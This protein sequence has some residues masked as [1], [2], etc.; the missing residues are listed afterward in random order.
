MD[1]I[2]GGN[3]FTIRILA[4]HQADDAMS[5]TMKQFGDEPATNEEAIQSAKDQVAAFHQPR[6]LEQTWNHVAGDLSGRQILRL[7][8]HDLI[9]HSW[10]IE[11]TLRPPANVPDDLVRW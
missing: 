2:T 5:A 9:V 8:L 4:G 1:H 7:R 11:E 6:A 10:D 3:W